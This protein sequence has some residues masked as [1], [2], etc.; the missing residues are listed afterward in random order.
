[1]SEP[2]LRV[3]EAPEKEAETTPDRCQGS[4]RR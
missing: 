1:M 2:P 3:R 4:Q